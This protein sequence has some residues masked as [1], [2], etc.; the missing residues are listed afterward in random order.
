VA[1]SSCRLENPPGIYSKKNDV[2]LSNL[3]GLTWVL[4]RRVALAPA[5]AAADV[6]FAK[7][8]VPIVVIMGR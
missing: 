3:T 6:I 7:L 4:L 8:S 2:F 5:S 1:Q